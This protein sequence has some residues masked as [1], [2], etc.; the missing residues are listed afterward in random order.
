MRVR[1]KVG[2][3]EGSGLEDDGVY[4]DYSYYELKENDR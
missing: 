2:V 3:R 1:V 4:A